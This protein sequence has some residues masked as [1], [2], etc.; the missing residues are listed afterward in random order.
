MSSSLS[1]LLDKDCILP[2]VEASI[3]ICVTNKFEIKSLK[4]DVNDWRLALLLVCG[5]GVMYL[6][7]MHGCC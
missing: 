3:L 4:V 2:W 7:V 1:K 5:R 6:G